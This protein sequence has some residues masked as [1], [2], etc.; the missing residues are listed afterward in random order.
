[1][2][3]RLAALALALGLAAAP[4]AADPNAAIERVIS[5]QIAAFQRDDMA[6]AFEFAGPGIRQKFATPENFG[7]M[8]RQGY[9]MIHRPARWE[10]RGLEGEGATRVKTVLFEDASGALHEADYLMGVVDGEWRIRGVRLR[11]LPGLSS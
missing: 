4:A 2:M 11:R 8:V 5:E 6:A 9:P 7:R 10:W 3:R 1:M